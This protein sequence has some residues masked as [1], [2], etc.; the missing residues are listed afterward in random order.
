M[1]RWYPSSFFFLVLPHFRKPKMTEEVVARI[2]AERPPRLLNQ[3]ERKNISVACSDS[4][5]GKWDDLIQ[6]WYQQAG[7]WNL[8]EHTRFPTIS[9]AYDFRDSHG[10]DVLNLEDSARINAYPN[11][12][13]PSA[14][15]ATTTSPMTPAKLREIKVNVLYQHLPADRAYV[16]QGVTMMI[17][18]DETEQDIRT[19]DKPKSWWKGSAYSMSR[20]A[21][22]YEWCLRDNT[23]IRHPWCEFDVIRFKDPNLPS[24]TARFSSSLTGGDGSGADPDGS[25]PPDPDGPKGP[26][27]LS[28]E[29]RRALPGYQ[30]MLTSRRMWMERL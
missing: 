15:Q 7:V 12:P 20:N 6:D 28:I 30:E 16:T 4:S 1:S 2:E 13:I 11:V 21:C 5:V 25:S 10:K 19:S 23:P 27:G 14:F 18:R 8:P 26:P 3:S 24:I 17:P 9:T 22:D 29:G